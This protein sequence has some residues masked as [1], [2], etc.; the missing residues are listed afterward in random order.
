MR[1]ATSAGGSA[2]TSPSVRS[3]QRRNEAQISASV[4]SIS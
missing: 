4:S 2:A 3:P 1:A